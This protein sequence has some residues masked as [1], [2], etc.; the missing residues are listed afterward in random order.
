MTDEAVEKSSVCCFR[1]NAAGN[2]IRV[3]KSVCINKEKGLSRLWRI[4]N[5]WINGLM[6]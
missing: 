6:D 3:D 2:S 5:W 4:Y 1:E